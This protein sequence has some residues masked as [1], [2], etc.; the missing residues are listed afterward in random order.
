MKQDKCAA[1]E[2]YLRLSFP[3][4]RIEQH[5]NFDLKTQS[6]KIHCSDGPRLLRVGNE[7][8]GNHDISEIMRRFQLWELSDILKKERE[9]GVLITHHGPTK[10]SW[11]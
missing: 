1:I 2:D 6:F 7:F 11:D 8:L 4:C 3:H 5:F 9:L 10:F